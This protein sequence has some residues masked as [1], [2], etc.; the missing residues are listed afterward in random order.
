M[1]RSEDNAWVP[2]TKYLVLLMILPLLVQYRW[3][4]SKVTPFSIGL[5]IP[6][7][8]LAIQAINYNFRNPLIYPFF[9]AT[10][11]FYLAPTL[12]SIWNTRSRIVSFALA[13]II[14]TSA[15]ILFE[16]LLW[17]IDVYSHSGFRAIGPFVNPNNTGII[18]AITGSIFHLNQKG[19]TYNL[20]VFVIVSIMIVLTGSK[21]AMALYAV[22]VILMTPLRWSVVIAVASLFGV[23]GLS[24]Y[25]LSITAG[26]SLRDFS[27]ASAIMRL[28]DFHEFMSVLPDMTLMQLLWGFSRVSVI[29]NAYLDMWAFGGAVLMLAFLAIQIA[30]VCVCVRRRFWGFLLLHGLF[31]LAMLTTNVPLLWPTG[32]MYWALV[33]LSFFYTSSPLA[34]FSRRSPQHSNGQKYV[35]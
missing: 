3:S 23:I 13:I 18:L 10:T 2:Y 5:I 27:A 29:D 8:A 20:L 25:T 26:F 24:G 31:A 14:V 21:T 4:R 32:Y 9:A 17:Q 30:A 11:G 33:G 16:L 7:L 35:L 15:S 22:A 19:G 6:I 12:T 1:I 34:N 28:N